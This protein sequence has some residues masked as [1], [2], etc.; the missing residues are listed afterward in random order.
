[1]MSLVSRKTALTVAFIFM[2]EHPVLLLLT[3]RGISG[4]S[5][6][7]CRTCGQPPEVRPMSDSSPMG[8]AKG[9]FLMTNGYGYEANANHAV[10]IHSRNGRRVGCGVLN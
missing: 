7:L 3:S 2:K 4:T 8:N 5:L 1:M 6:L 10:V 9:Y